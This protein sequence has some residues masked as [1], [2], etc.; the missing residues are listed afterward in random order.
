MSEEEAKTLKELGEEN[1]RLR[2]LLGNSA[3]PCVY[4]GLPA[5]QQSECARGF[6]GCARGDDQMLSKHFADGWAVGEYR[7]EVVTLRDTVSKLRNTLDYTQRMLEHAVNPTQRAE[8]TRL[9]GL[10]LTEV[11]TKI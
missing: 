1:D 2:A 9:L 8:L 4:C 11:D 6:P 3:L 10:T 5:D 7:K